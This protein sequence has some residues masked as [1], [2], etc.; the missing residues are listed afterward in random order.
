[1]DAIVSSC[2][3]F[4]YLYLQLNFD[5]VES[6]EYILPRDEHL[7]AEWFLKSK[8]DIKMD[9]VYLLKY[10]EEN[11]WCRAQVLEII[12]DSEVNTFSN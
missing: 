6:L 11:L 7:D 10:D 3:K 12:N 9:H 1:M 4:G 5:V 2:P 8:E